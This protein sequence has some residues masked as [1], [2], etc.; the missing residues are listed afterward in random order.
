MVTNSKNY[1][2]IQKEFDEMFEKKSSILL[3]NL[4]KTVESIYKSNKKQEEIKK[5]K[6]IFDEI[7]EEKNKSSRGK[8]QDRDHGDERRSRKYS[9]DEFNLGG[10]KVVLKNAKRDN[11][12]SND[13]KINMDRSRSRENDFKNNFHQPNYMS[14]YGMFPFPPRMAMGMGIPGMTQMRGMGMMGRPMMFQGRM[15]FHNKQ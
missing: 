14:P 6:D 13:A 7:A 3:N 1:S 8:Y 4:V 2:E 15:Q 5:N 12:N 11:N 10:K 9:K